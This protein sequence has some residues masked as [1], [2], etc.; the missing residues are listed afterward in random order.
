MHLQG[1]RRMIPRFPRGS[2]PIFIPC[3]SMTRAVATLARRIVLCDDSRTYASA[4]T[5]TLERDGS[6]SV[7]GVF[8]TAEKAIA[9]LPRLRPDLVTMDLELPGMS[10]LDAIQEIMAASPTPVVVV[11]D[12]AGRDSATASAALAAGAVDTIPKGELDLRDPGSLVSA[13]LRRRLVRLSTTTVVRHPRARPS[14]TPLPCAEGQRSVAAIGVC[15]STGGPK[16]LVRMLEA[17]PVTFPIPILVVQHITPGFVSSLAS[18]LDRGIDLPVGI[19]TEGMR[20]RSGVWLAPEGAHLR[21]RRSGRVELARVLAGDSYCPSGDVLLSS[22]AEAFGSEAA[23]IVLTGMGSDGARGIGA[24]RVHGGLAIA[25]DEGSAA[26]F[27]MPRAA[28]EHGAQVVLAP[29]AI[30]R[31]LAR[32]RP[33]A[34]RPEPGTRAPSNEGR[35]HLRVVR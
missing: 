30:G 26:V 10:G 25:Q 35:P 17:L 21:V 15:A 18:T 34:G 7:A 23:G 32:L 19:A 16:T 5:R 27:G 28:I 29:E 8:P 14:R 11:S 13:S 12:Y 24:L 20:L 31:L 3:W 6:L 4:L 2:H 1:L 22:L 33:V 9:Q